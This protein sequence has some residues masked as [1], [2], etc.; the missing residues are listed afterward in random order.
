MGSLRKANVSGSGGNDIPS[1]Q[2]A[3][4]EAIQSMVNS[5]NPRSTSL[6]VDALEFSMSETHI[7][8]PT[9]ERLIQSLKALLV[10]GIEK[11]IEY[12]ENHPDFPMTG[13]HMEN[14]AR[15]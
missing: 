14:F 1:G 2:L 15:R 10:K 3:F 5:D 13:D 12:D 4:L 6:V 11:V 7:M 8:Q 9:R